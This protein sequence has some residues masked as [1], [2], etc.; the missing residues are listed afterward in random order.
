MWIGGSGDALEYDMRDTIGF[1]YMTESRIDITDEDTMLLFKDS[2]GYPRDLKRGIADGTI[3]YPFVFME[4]KNV[5]DMGVNSGFITSID[6]TPD[7]TI[8]GTMVPG[9][10][11]LPDLSDV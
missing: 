8:T 6:E 1:V 4:F 11:C 9:P 2:M 3:P 7:F 5:N 10:D